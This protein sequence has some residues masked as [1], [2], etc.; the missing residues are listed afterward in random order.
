MNTKQLLSNDIKNASARIWKEAK[1]EIPPSE[2]NELSRLALEKSKAYR[3]LR[4]IEKIL[5]ELNELLQAN[6]DSAKGFG[7][8]KEQTEALSLKARVNNW[9]NE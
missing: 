9:E 8:K 1:T 2:A 4:E 6:V 3:K 7:D 5:P